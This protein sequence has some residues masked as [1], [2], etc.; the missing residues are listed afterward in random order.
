MGKEEEDSGREGKRKEKGVAKK[1]GKRRW[2]EKE[3]EKERK[4]MDNGI[5]KKGRRERE[6][7]MVKRGDSGKKG[8]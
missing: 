5:D 4:Y 7:R 6:E 3:E 1:D 8:A 2:K